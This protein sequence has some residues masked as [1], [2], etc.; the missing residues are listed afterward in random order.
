VRVRAG[1]RRQQIDPLLPERL[2]VKAGCDELFTA[3]NARRDP[4]ATGSCEHWAGEPGSL[5]LLWGARRT[6]RLIPEIAEPDT[7]GALSQLID[8]WRDHVAALPDASELDTAAIIDWPSRD[9]EG[10]KPLL[11]RG[12]AATHV[13]A[14]RVTDRYELSSGDDRRAARHTGISIRR[15][16]PSDIDSI[17]RFGLGQVGYDAHF[18][19]VVE[20]PGAEQTFRR[21]AAGLLEEPEPWIWLAEQD[22]AVVGALTAERPDAAA[23]IAPLTALTPVAY[24]MSMFVLPQIRG[25]RVGA[26]LTD[27]FHHEVAAAGVTVTL[28]HY[29]PLNPLSLPFWSQQ[30]YRPLWITLEARP[31]L[32]LREVATPANIRNP[33][34]NECI[35]GT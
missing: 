6:Y 3:T 24:L 5:D 10:I 13:I 21:Y 8:Q 34:S 27:R 33:L 12:L 32:S 25:G 1:Q 16:E 31:A 19:G 9:I 17:A 11:A 4:I 30:G 18:G 35:E 2:D 23:W 20:R 26:M 14:A 15:A 7:A 29:E 22:G 28:L